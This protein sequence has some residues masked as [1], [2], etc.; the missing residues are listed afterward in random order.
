MA[1]SAMR[2][3]AGTQTSAMDMIPTATAAMDHAMDMGL[4]SCKVN[5]TWI[6]A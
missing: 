6:D 5:V 1:S 2:N 4:G 3:M